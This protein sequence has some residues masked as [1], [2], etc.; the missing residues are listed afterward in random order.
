MELLIEVTVE[1][2]AGL[3]RSRDAIEEAVVE[4]I[5]NAGDIEIDESAFEIGDVTVVADHR[6][7]LVK[8]L[9]D[10][11]MLVASWASLAAPRANTLRRID[12]ARQAYL[13][14][15]GK[16]VLTQAPTTE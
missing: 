12:R 14:G 1:R 13:R 15:G 16:G 10:M 9:G 3:N 11:L 5:Q 7:S 4:L 6:A 2:T 8:A